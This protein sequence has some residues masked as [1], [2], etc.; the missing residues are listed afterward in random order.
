[1]TLPQTV[2]K[3]L[4]VPL[5]VAGVALGAVVLSG[6]VG[7]ALAMFLTV[8][9][10]NAEPVLADQSQT[11]EQAKTQACNAFAVAGRRW[12][13]AYRE[14]L[15][16]MRTPGWQWSDPDVQSATAR[17]SAVEAEVAAQL[18]GLVGPNTPP[19][20][21][22]AIRGY[23]NALLEYSADHYMADPQAMHDQETEINDAAADVTRACA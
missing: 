2:K 20:V 9:R 8:D 11:P 14:W 6:V 10:R 3:R 1:M 21:A 22:Q 15:P 18:N 16:A 4:G 17:F 23:T 7:W 13:E 19:D 5:W 12:V